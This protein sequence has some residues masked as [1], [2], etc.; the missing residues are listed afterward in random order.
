MPAY[1]TT[2]TPQLQFISPGNKIALVNNAAVDTGITATI[3]VSCAAQPNASSK[4]TLVN[5]TNQTATVQ[6][7]AV[8]ASANYVPLTAT[9]TAAA[10][11]AVVFDCIGPWIRASFASAPTAGSLYLCR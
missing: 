2:S 10:G 7:A 3:Q 8:D 4:L 6:V 11:A 5:N 1:Q 9:V